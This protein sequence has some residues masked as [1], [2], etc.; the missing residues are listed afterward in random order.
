MPA[1]KTVRIR[2]IEEAETIMDY[3]HHYDSPLGG[4]TL[5]CDGEALTGLWFDGQRYFGETLDPMHEEALLPVL[6]EAVRWLDL[7][8]G[9]RAPGFL[10]K[11]RLRAT[12][13]RITVWEILLAVPYG[14]TATYKEI[15]ERTAK[16]LCLP[17]MSAQAVGGAV[18][19]NPVSLII[20]CHRVVGAD[21]SLTGYAG[22]MERKRQLLEM[23]KR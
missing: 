23:E 17:G 11:L 9:G 19:H 15:A 1:A 20:P 18:S 13:F 22:G 12:P 8:F 2:I 16:R 6:G 3:I 10:P 7:Y 14:K 4:I 21:G 5:A